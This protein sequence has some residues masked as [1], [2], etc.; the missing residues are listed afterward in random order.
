MDKFRIKRRRAED[1]SVTGC[2][3]DKSVTKPIT[4]VSFVKAARRDVEFNGTNRK[5]TKIVI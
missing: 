4:N 2:D 5:Y 3:I 1:E